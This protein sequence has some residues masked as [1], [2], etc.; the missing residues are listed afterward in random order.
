[1]ELSKP[2]YDSTTNVLGGIPDYAVMIDYIVGEESV[3]S[4]A[5]NFVFRTTKATSRFKKAISDGFLA[6]KSFEHKK[7]FLEA[8]MSKDFSLEEKLIILFWQLT[9][10]NELYKEITDQVFLRA[11]YSGRT[12]IDVND[13]DAYIHH[14]KK[15]SPEDIPWT[16][17]TIHTTASKYLTSLKKFG[18]AL[19]TNKKEIHA[20]HISSSLFVYLVKLAMTV[21]PDEKTLDNP[22]FRFSFLDQQSTINRL[23]TIEYIPLWDITQIGNDVT[24]KLK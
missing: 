4:A 2:K 8:L 16:D 11:L 13:V 1:M 6:Y 23:K 10:C 20:P 12:S 17:S 5:D 18:F 14:L 22:L 9:V 19:G 7:L 24:I 3:E 15:E 21:F